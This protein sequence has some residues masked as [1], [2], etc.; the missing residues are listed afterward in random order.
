MEEG[1]N[2]SLD[3]FKRMK[4]NDRETVIFQNVMYIKNQGKNYNMN[5]TLQYI[6]LFVLSTIMGIRKFLPF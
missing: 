5:R 1:L 3:E 4:K 6:W 2:V